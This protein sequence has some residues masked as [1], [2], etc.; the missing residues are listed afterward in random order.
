ML[1]SSRGLTFL[2]EYD[3]F[4]GMGCPPMPRN[5]SHAHVGRNFN[6]RALLA[7]RLRAIIVTGDSQ[8][9]GIHLPRQFA[10]SNVAS[11]FGR[12]PW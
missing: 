8:W 7:R 4:R 1:R 9:I 10:L 5:F 11:H 2:I 6:G 3:K 12:S